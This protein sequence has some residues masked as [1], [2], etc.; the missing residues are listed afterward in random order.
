[1][2][3]IVTASTDKSSEPAL[4]KEVTALTKAAFASYKEQGLCLE[5]RQ[6]A[7]HCSVGRIQ[8]VGRGDTHRH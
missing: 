1:M 7:V 5:P 4:H 8:V 6:H 3:G 2:Q